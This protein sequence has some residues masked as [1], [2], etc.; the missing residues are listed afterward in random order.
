MVAADSRPPSSGRCTLVTGPASSGKS[1]W[2][3]TLALRSRLP[4][5]Y[6]ATG[7]QRPDDA[8]WQER[9]RRHRQRRP[10]HWR[11]QEVGLD[12]VAALARAEAGTLVLV[13]SLGTWVAAGLDLDESA[14]FAQCS[15]LSDVVRRAAA[16]LVLVGEE[17][18]WGV[19]PPTA[20]G[21]RFRQ[22]LGSLLQQLMP[23]CD[24]AW[25][26]LHGRALNLLGLSEPVPDALET[27]N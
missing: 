4:V 20:V 11:C 23:A 1:L 14:W 9:L 13:D 18:A 3:E 25:L 19:V 8:A 2:A 12:L 16:E 26:V 21:G 6:L 15:A 17:T 24:A 22:R 5:V 10:S 27:G 7:P